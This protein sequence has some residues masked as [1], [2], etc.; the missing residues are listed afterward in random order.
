ME[1]SIHTDP[2]KFWTFVRNKNRST[3]IPGIMKLGDT[4]LDN[5]QEI[6][7]NIYLK[8]V[9]GKELE[10]MAAFQVDLLSQKELQ[11]LSKPHI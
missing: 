10:P 1:N 9:T 8:K 11:Q 2:S 5:T 7:Y 4:T 6:L 3:R